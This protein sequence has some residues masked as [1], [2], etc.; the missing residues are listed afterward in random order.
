MLL[1]V[2]S[3]NDLAVK[4]ESGSIPVDDGCLLRGVGFVTLDAVQVARHPRGRGAAARSV[5]HQVRTPAISLG[6]NAHE[7]VIGWTCPDCTAAINNEGAIGPS[8]M[9]RSLIA[10]LDPGLL[11]RMAYTLAE[12]PHLVG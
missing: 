8:A 3:P 1:A 5:W 7:D 11:G 2:P 10:H 12:V 9:E 6:A 4:P